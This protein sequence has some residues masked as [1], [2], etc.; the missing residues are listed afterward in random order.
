MYAV[1]SAISG[2]VQKFR[3]GYGD[4]FLLQVGYFTLFSLYIYLLYVKISVHES[5]CLK[6]KYDKV[7]SNTGYQHKP[8]NTPFKT[9]CKI[10]CRFELKSTRP[11]LTDILDQSIKWEQVW[12]QQ[13]ELWT[14]KLMLTVVTYITMLYKKECHK[15][16]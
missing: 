3:G 7:R 12:T 15:S 10:H 5:P 11:D 4:N 8:C 14:I 2:Y 16:Q 1:V 6:D 13:F 9:S